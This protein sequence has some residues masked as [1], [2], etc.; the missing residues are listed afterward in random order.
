MNYQY[1]DLQ[2]RLER[3]P[4]KHIYLSITPQGEIRLRVPRHMSDQSIDRFLASKITWIR[5]KLADLPRVEPRRWQSGEKV[6]LLGECYR[7]QLTDAARAQPELAASEL[8]MPTQS[9][10]QMEKQLKQF[11]RKQLQAYLDRRVPE[12]A[13]RMQ[14]SPKEWRIRDMRTRWGSCNPSAGRLWFRLQL[15]QVHP[16]LIDLV[17]VHELAHLEEIRHNSNFYQIV[18]RYIPDY[19]VKKKQ[20]EQAKLDD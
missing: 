17:I 3:K 12:L 14:L 5:A 1:K 2:L 13:Q 6:M 8:R 20:L 11:Y 18:E 4:N 16:D 19:R 10:E 7:L 15:A 9:V